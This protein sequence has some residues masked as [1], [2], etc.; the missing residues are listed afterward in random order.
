[1]AIEDLTSRRFGRVIVL[2]LNH[3]H[4]C[5]SCTT[6]PMWRCKCDCGNEVIVNA[7]SLKKGLTQSCG[8]LRKEKTASK[9]LSHG[10][11]DSRLYRI[12]KGMKSRC[13]NP[14][15]TTYHNYGARG[16]SV[17]EGWIQDFTSFRNWSLEN[18]Y[19][20]D[21]SI[22]RI[23]ND[24]DYC[25]EN[26]RWTDVFTQVNNS[27]HNH[28]VVL[29]GEKH[30]ITEWSRIFEVN[31]KTFSYWVKKDSSEEAILNRLEKYRKK[32][33]L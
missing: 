12:Y 13:Y 8:C 5:P 24:G 11:S 7:S 6:F 10:E 20:E 22:D 18:G 26:C 15:D 21:L 4:T 19:A 33:G 9:N 14:N 23:D 3:I 25:P 32:K 31:V 17:C 29:G 2:E 1:M 16:I 28:F 30:T 27:R